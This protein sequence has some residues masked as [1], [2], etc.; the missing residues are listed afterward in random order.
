MDLPVTLFFIAV[1][2]AIKG[3]ALVLAAIVL[4]CTVI[5]ARRAQCCGNCP[6]K[7][8]WHACK[9]SVLVCLLGVAVVVTLLM[10]VPW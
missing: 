7:G 8:A 6:R 10:A 9:S 2:S 3:Y 4:V 1:L 5:G